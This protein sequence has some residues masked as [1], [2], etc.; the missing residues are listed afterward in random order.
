M[1]NNLN[2]RIIIYM[3]NNYIFIIKCVP[4]LYIPF[5]AVSNYLI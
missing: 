1:R 4:N 5:V 2:A 3:V